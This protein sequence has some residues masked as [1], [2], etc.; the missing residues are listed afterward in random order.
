MLNEFFL[1]VGLTI[2]WL[3]LET[4]VIVLL[5]PIR[6][7][8]EKGYG[9]DL[10]VFGYTVFPALFGS[11]FYSWAGFAGSLFGSLIALYA[12]FIIDPMFRSRDTPTIIGLLNKK[13]GVFKN[14]LALLATVIAVPCFVNLRLAEI[15]VYPMLTFLVKL[16]PYKQG[17]WVNVSRHKYDGLTGA[18]LVWCLY[19][20]W[21]TGV[22][23][24]KVRELRDRFPR[25]RRVGC[26]G[27]EIG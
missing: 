16:P 18:D 25:H 5:P 13:V 1:T 9:L 27:R 20:D 6:R 11:I 23:S 7:I 19:C 24:R 14:N 10:A 12:F 26:P 2:A 22:Y 15:L 21:M 3:T 4:L 8:A 17:D